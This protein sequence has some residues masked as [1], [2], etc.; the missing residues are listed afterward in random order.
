MFT[1]FGFP[2]ILQSQMTTCVSQLG[3][4]VSDNVIFNGKLIQLLLYMC[5]RSGAQPGF[6]IEGEPGASEAS[7]IWGQAPSENFKITVYN[8]RLYC[9]RAQVPTL[10][11]PNAGHPTYILYF[12]E[13]YMLYNNTLIEFYDSNVTQRRLNTESQDL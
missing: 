5:R 12:C 1:H 7:F 8:D 4:N 9:M 6:L 11:S 3:H 2:I 10:Q 13:I